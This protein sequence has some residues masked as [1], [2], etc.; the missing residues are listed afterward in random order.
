MSA[1]TAI[2]IGGGIAGLASAALLA[3]DGFTVTLLERHAHFGGRAGEWIGHSDAGDF[4]FETGPS[5]YLMPDVFDRFFARFGTTTDEELDLVTLDPG[6]RVWFEGESQ[7]FDVARSAT[8]N[9]ARFEAIEPGAGAVLERYLA[10]ADEAYR[11]ALDRFLYTDFTS[12]RSLATKDVLRRLPRLTRLL[13]QSL[14]SHVASRFHDRRLRQILGYPAVFLGSSPDRAPALYSLMSRLDLAD[15]VRYPLGGFRALIDRIA[16]IAEREGA[17]LRSGVDV[18]S[19]TTEQDARGRSRATGVTYR[20]PDGADGRMEADVVVATADLHAV[21]TTMLPRPL[22][23]YPESWWAKRVPGPGAVLVLLGVEGELPALD[24]HTLFFTED[25]DQNFDAIFGEHPHIPDPA[26]VYVCRPSATDAVAPAGH[27]NLFVLIPVPANP[28]IGRGGTDG[29][30]DAAV[31]AAA[32][33]AIALIAE[34]T[35]TPDLAGRVRVR[36]TIGPGDFADDFSSWRGTALG[37]AHTLRQS[38]M[39]RGRNRSAKVAGL[40]YAGGSTIPGIGLP[41]CLISAELA[42]AAAAG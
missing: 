34:W 32:D 17:E 27:E 12:L 42:A 1:P 5:W 41:M 13:L 25:W 8:E 23:T 35:G 15:G 21:E 7:P 40:I 6:Y 3:R 22:Q 2:V 14:Q 24:H 28:R 38:A 19:I 18:L 11:I 39:F 37:P 30:G 33:R 26:S 4:R 16:A 31:E 29:A 36:R 20:T 10:D 9:M